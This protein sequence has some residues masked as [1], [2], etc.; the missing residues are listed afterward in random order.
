MSNS[1]S[2]N[3]SPTINGNGNTANV[4]SVNHD[5]I[6]P[7]PSDRNQAEDSPEHQKTDGRRKVAILTAIPE[8]CHAIRRYFPDLKPLIYP[9]SGK[10]FERA[11]LD[12]DNHRW[13]VLL[14]ETG[15]GNEVAG[16]V[17]A[18]VLSRF[19]PDLMLFIGIAGTLRDAQIGDLIIPP[20]VY[21][22]E[23]TKDGKTIRTRPQA[24]SPGSGALEQARYLSKQDDWQPRSMTS[25][26]RIIPRVYF[27]PIASGSKVLDS[28]KADLYQMLRNT[29]N[30]AIGIDME[31][32]GFLS[33]VQ[34][35]SETLV[36]GLVIRA[37]SDHLDDKA[38]ADAAGGQQQASAN[39]AAFIIALLERWL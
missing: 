36:N 9:S 6:N 24:C 35:H 25:N 20:K 26:S 17:T 19:E 21:S 30:D 34:R 5:A 16:S 28:K 7:H 31:S 4:F 38:K 1:Y 14:G 22:Y 29:F 12:G 8:E 2:N 10:I 27:K 23:Y 3:F 32:Y 18:E 11:D 15:P 33:E 13:D 39:A 37:V